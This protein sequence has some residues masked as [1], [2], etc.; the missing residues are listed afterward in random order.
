MS[1]P[2]LERILDVIATRLAAIDGTGNYTTEI[3][4]NIRRSRIQPHD[5]DLPCVCLFLD[6]RSAS[7]RWKSTRANSAD[8]W[9][10]TVP[11]WSLSATR[12][13]TRK[14]ATA[15]LAAT[16]NTERRTCGNGA[17]LK[18]PERGMQ[19]GTI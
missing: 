4:C 6:A 8:C 16:W 1:A 12:S 15:W 18:Q 7:A 3:G 13:C 11:A 17:T 19:N 9:A 10:V 14:R 5:E 2:K